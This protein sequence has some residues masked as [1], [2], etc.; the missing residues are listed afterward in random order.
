MTSTNIQLTGGR[1]VLSGAQPMSAVPSAAPVMGLRG[2]AMCLNWVP[3][4]ANY[5]ADRWR[6][7]DVPS[8]VAAQAGAVLP[9]SAHVESAPQ[10]GFALRN[11]IAS[12]ETI[13]TGTKRACSSAL[14]RSP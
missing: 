8:L 11:A 13:P 5:G 12:T 3:Q 10:H 2:A 7:V 9:V 14:E 1:Q 4:A 6:V